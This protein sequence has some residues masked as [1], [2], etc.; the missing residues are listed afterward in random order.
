MANEKNSG[1]GQAQN[2]DGRVLKSLAL[3][4]L[5]WISFQR[6]M[7]AMMKKGIEDTSNAR[8][9]QNLAARELQALMMIFDRSGKWRGLLD[10]GLESKIAET[11][12]ETLPKL[13]SGSLGLIE[14]QD[15]LLASVADL[16]DNVRKGDKT[17]GPASGR[18]EKSG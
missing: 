3:L 9:V 12:K 2:D 10:H 7:L 1:A 18:T 11:Y 8:P 16:L 5:P 13:V 17:S 14:A 15:A 6:E 4:T